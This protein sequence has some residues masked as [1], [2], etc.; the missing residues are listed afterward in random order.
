[1]KRFINWILRSSVDP[2]KLSLMVKGALVSAFSILGTVLVLFGFNGLPANEINIFVEN[3]AQTVG[4][5][6][7]VIGTIILAY[8]AIRKIY[9][10]AT[11][12]DNAG[13]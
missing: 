2:K 12:K 8:G 6:G 10:T 11:S 13:I 4:A 9:L 7:E 1:M 3:A 5:L